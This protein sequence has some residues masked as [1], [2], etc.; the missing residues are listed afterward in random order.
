ML[1][2]QSKSRLPAEWE[3]Q[4][5]IL[6]AW[7]H[8]H[9]DWVDLLDEV[10]QVYL[11]ITRQIVRFE[12]AII[13]SPSPDKVQLKLADAG[14]S[15]SNIYFLQADTND[16]WARDFGPISVFHGD[17]LRQLDFT[18]NG[19]GHKFPAEKDNRVT[20]QLNQSDIVKPNQREEI[21]LVLEG[22]SIEVDGHGTLL[23]TSQCLLNHNRN[24]NL[25]RADIEVQLAQNFGI[26]QFLW[27]DSGELAGDDTDAHIDT[28]ARLCPESTILYVQ[29]NNPE[30]EHFLQLK[31]MEEQLKEFK[32]RE[33]SSFRLSPLPWPEARYNGEERL[34]ATYANYLVV[35]GAVLV[36]IYQDPADKQ[37]LK[38][39]Q[40][41]FPDREVIG[42]DCLPLIK[43]HGSL[44]CI[45]MQFPA[46]VLA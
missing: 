9:T 11:N 34:P 37:A 23:T 46:G 26:D 28:L 17:E 5:A 13:V 38:V 42:I 4:D 10:E 27:L 6:L 35:N 18:F 19:W 15:L 36:P 12:A 1:S 8:E 24:P 43:Q 2:Q 39:I 21:D 40:Q 30:D 25:T 33:G 3:Q 14:V 29:C 7:P 31:K 20:A 32:T 22:G 44:H 41:A 16:T 45:T